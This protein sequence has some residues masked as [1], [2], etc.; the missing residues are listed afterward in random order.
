[1]TLNIFNMVGFKQFDIFKRP[2]AYSEPWTTN[3]LWSSS[4]SVD[5]ASLSGEEAFV[6]DMLKKY[7]SVYNLNGRIG[8]YTR[9]VYF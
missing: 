9:E 2:R 4:A 5:N 3:E 8:I 1:M 7:S 6:P